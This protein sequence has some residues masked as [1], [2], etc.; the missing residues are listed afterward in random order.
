MEIITNNHVI[1]DEEVLS[2]NE[3]KQFIG[4]N[5]VE[6]TLNHLKNDCIIPVFSKDNE[7]TI[8]HYEFINET[9]NIVEDLLPEFTPNKPNIRVSHMIKG[10]IPSAIGKPVK[11]LVEHEKTI[12]YERCAFLIE[13]PQIQTK[14]QNNTLS[15]TVGGVRSLNQE[16]LY[17]KK[18]VEKFKV[19]IGFQNKVCTNL[20][21]STDGL[22]NEIRISSISELHTGILN[23]F[24]EYNQQE[25]I[26]ALNNMSS[27][28][29][30]E[31]QFAHLIGRLRMYQH[32]P[33]NEQCGIFPVLLN[34]SQINNVVK[35]YYN[36]SNFSRNSNGDI[37]LWRLYNLLTEANK[38]SYIDSFLERSV[39]SFELVQ[40]IGVSLKNGTPNWF[41]N[42]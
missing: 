14:I 42:N 8:S 35:E 41:L 31:K 16:N 5:T 28:S 10:R 38:S 36:C 25:Q 17:S 1:R 7:T 13:I 34:D 4:A 3:N 19:F 12:Y 6:V 26:E 33:K 32:L 9:Q 37:N 21:V 40:N 27:H 23:L 29:L 2:I 30:S 15:L 22:C 18:T 39:N 24:K 11:E 20:C